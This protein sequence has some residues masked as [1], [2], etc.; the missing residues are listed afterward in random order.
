[1]YGNTTN[2]MKPNQ[3]QEA[4]EELAHIDATLNAP[5]HVRARISDPR[6]MQKRR[7]ALREQLDRYTPRPYA[8]SELD[9]AIKEFNRLADEIHRDMPSSA[10]MRRNPAGAVGKHMSWEKRNETNIPCYKHIGLRLLATGA[11][12]D[13]LKH[14]GDIT[15]VE[16][17][18]PLD[19][20]NDLVDGAQIPKTTDY[21]FGAEVA[22][23][24]LFSDEELKAA[25]ELDPDIAGALAVMDNEQRAILKRHIQEML[26]PVPAASLETASFAEVTRAAGRVGVK[27][28]GRKREDIVADLKAMEAKA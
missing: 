13:S 10:E 7:R 6:A 4:K 27:T 25:D 2:L 23:S 14:G 28:F 5:P 19:T 18:R 16:R 11:V 8:R 21:H 9:A 17:L 12:P 3:V 24:V 26:N 1:M 22:T 15:N 20:P